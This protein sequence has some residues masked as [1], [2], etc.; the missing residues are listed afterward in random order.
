[1]ITSSVHEDAL[2]MSL[3]VYVWGAVRSILDDSTT[4]DTHEI[5]LEKSHKK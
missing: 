4:G 1:M 3:D 2:D 5:L